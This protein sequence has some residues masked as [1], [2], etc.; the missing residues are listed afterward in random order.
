MGKKMRTSLLCMATIVLASLCFF[1]CKA[2]AN[3]SGPYVYTAGYKDASL[4]STAKVWRNGKK[5][6]EFTSSAEDGI[7]AHD[8][9][10]QNG[11]IYVTGR[12]YTTNKVV[13]LWKNGTE[14][15]HT[16]DTKNAQV[17]G[18]FV[19]SGEDWY[20]AGMEGTTAKV[21]KNG[22][23]ITAFTKD[24]TTYEAIVVANGSV[25]VSG[26]ASDKAT[27]WKD[28]TQLYKDSSADTTDALSLAVASNGDVYTAVQR[29][30]GA[31]VNSAEIWKNNSSLYVLGGTTTDPSLP[32]DL[33][34]DGADLYAIG[35]IE[36]T[37]KA[38]KNGTVLDDY[39]Q[40]FSSADYECITVLDGHLYVAGK[41]IEGSTINAVVWKDGAK[42]Y[43]M[44]NGTDCF[45]M[46]IVK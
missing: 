6:Y 10:I 43:T 46:T 26:K 38:W 3:D 20:I 21:W 28:G 13:R 32:S 45:G 31:G 9:A 4:K 18:L 30:T 33:Y 11:N 37:S 40:A 25:Y 27:V 29:L 7:Q 35:Y 42:L 8:I 41:S 1:G 2:S 16:D 23:A 44:E 24:D 34:L 17:G 14:V 15:F 36:G 39:T 12:E 19:T 5:V 22:T